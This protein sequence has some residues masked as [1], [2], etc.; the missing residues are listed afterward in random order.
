LPDEEAERMRQRHP[1]PAQVLLCLGVIV[2]AAA[3]GAASGQQDPS[4]LAGVQYLRGR[5]ANMQSGESAMIALG[6]LKA[7]V[8][9]TDPAVVGCLVRCRSRFTESGYIPE[10]TDGR[11]VYEA[12]A[13]TLAM[14][15]QDPAENLAWIR[16]LAGYLIGA[17]KPNG[18]WDYSHRSAGDTSIS[19]YAVL[20][21][22]E[23]E[24]A[25]V[26]I[27][28]VVWDRAADWFLSTQGAAG[29][30]TYHRDEAAAGADTLSMTAAGVGS[31]LICQRQLEQFRQSR[32]GISPLMTPLTAESWAHFKPATTAAQIDQAVK[33]GMTWLSANFSL[34]NVAAIGHSPFYM[35]YGIERIGALAER[36]TIGRVDWYERGRAFI[37]SSQQTDGSW[38]GTYGIEMNTVWAMLFVTKSTAKT[39]QKI[40]IKR[41]GAGT[42]LGGRGLPSDLTSLTVAG[43]RVVSRPMNGAIEGMLAVLEDPRAE[44]AEAAV[45]GLVDRYYRE[46]PEALRTYK[47]R[48]RKM[49]TDRDPGV[50]R[51]AVWAL[52]HTADLDVAPLLI[53]ALV[54]PEEEVVAAAR[55]GL[56]VLSRKIEGLG[57]PSPSTPEQR[58][59]AAQRWRDWFNAIRPL[60]LDEPE[61]PSTG[62]PGGAGATAAGGPPRSSTP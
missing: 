17:Q 28:P 1:M 30:W 55:L 52:A 13:V 14:V 23:A 57:P 20:G 16:I 32:R 62:R 43:G 41:L 47:A 40:Q 54:D 33:R 19:Q 21:L 36:Q 42:L 11:G 27:P 6:L 51:V 53:D 60:D 46:G 10:L 38:N 56:Q 45:A 26:T 58:R 44:Q 37:H 9:P 61:Y 3:P 35:L 15:N 50:R 25:G 29:S 22:W 48:F 7:E 31:L 39:I 24:N 34:T 49:L 5:Y 4:V 8:P 18:S 12:A 2:A 59:A